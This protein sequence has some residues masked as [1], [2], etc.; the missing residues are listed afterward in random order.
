MDTIEPQK[1]KGKEFSAKYAQQEAM[2]IRVGTKIMIV[3]HS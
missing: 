1:G 2:Q 3:E